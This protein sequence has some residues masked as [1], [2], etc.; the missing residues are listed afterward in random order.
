MIFVFLFWGL[1]GGPRLIFGCLLV[2]R[3]CFL[4]LQESEFTP[5]TVEPLELYLEYKC[6]TRYL[7]QGSNLHWAYRLLQIC[8]STAP[9]FLLK[10]MEHFFC[11]KTCTSATRRCQR[12][13]DV[14]ILFVCRMHPWFPCS[15][16]VKVIHSDTIFHRAQN[17]F[18]WVVGTFHWFLPRFN[19]I[20]LEPFSEPQAHGALLV[21]RRFTWSAS[22]ELPTRRD[23]L[24]IFPY[25]LKETNPYTLKWLGCPKSRM[26]FQ[27]GR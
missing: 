24:P 13:H 14:T 15:S 2:V 5:K 10:Q 23:Y 16:R 22:S 17:V 7:E 18:Y 9:F 20:V 26:C 1:G 8:I 3:P 19:A 12:L 21:F 25:L 27:N 4:G 6:W 11:S